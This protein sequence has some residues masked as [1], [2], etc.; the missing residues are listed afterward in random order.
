LGESKAVAWA[1]DK[2]DVGPKLWNRL[3]QSFNWAVLL[4]FV[5]HVAA[6]LYFWHSEMP[7]FVLGWAVYWCV[8]LWSKMGREAG[9][10]WWAKLA[11]TGAAGFAGAVGSL[12]VYGFLGLNMLG[13]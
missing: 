3:R 2:K 4:V 1:A 8:L 5:A 11:V 7:V 9:P 10:E 12:I 13:S 6:G